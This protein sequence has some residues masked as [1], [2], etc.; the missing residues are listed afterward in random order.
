MACVIETRDLTRRFGDFTAVDQVSLCVDEGSIYGFLGPNGSGKTTLIRVL[1]GLLRATQGSA[2]VLGLD[3]SRET[4]RIKSSIGYMSQQ[5]SLY[6]DLTVLENLRFYGRIYSIPRSLLD[7]RIEE[8]IGFVGIGEYRNRQAQQLSGGWKQRLALACALIH[9]PKLVFLDEPTAGIDPV[10]RRNLWDLL[11]QLSEQGITFFVTTHYMDEAERC[12]HVGYIYFAKLL[13]HGTPG[14]L[15]RLPEISPCGT[16][17]LEVRCDRLPQALARMREFAQVRDATI[18]GDAMHV[19]VDEGSAHAVV[20]HLA[21]NDFGE[22]SAR[23][24]PPSL[25][26]VFVTLTRSQDHARDV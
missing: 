5:F 11:F 1:C 18:F 24:I 13:A 4:E 7:K 6:G 14:E 3:V 2:V 12:S 17:R 22:V 10:A 21:A 15:K 8:M 26:D 16:E 19:V 20:D 23:P 25:E 9:R